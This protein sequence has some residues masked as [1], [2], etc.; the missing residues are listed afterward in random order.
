MTIISKVQLTGTLPICCRPIC[1]KDGVKSGPQFIP[2]SL[3]GS[4]GRRG[5]LF[6]CIVKKI[7]SITL[8]LALHIGPPFIFLKSGK[9]ND[10]RLEQ[11]HFQVLSRFYIFKKHDKQDTVFWINQKISP[12]F[13]WMWRLI[14]KQR[15][16]I[17]HHRQ[18]IP[19]SLREAQPPHTKFLSCLLLILLLTWS[20]LE[21]YYWSV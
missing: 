17:T 20:S 11:L 9:Y 21:L 16:Y 19:L 15:N 8:I 14:E 12:Q 1:A 13:I 2:V 18:S 5:V 4:R 7:K 3:L 10:W 6:A